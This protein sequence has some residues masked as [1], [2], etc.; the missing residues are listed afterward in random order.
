MK[1]NSTSLQGKKSTPTAKKGGDDLLDA[2]PEGIQ[3]EMNQHVRHTFALKHLVNFAK[4]SSIPD[5]V[6]IILNKDTAPLQASPI[7]F[8]VAIQPLDSQYT[9]SQLSFRTI[10]VQAAFSTL[11]HP[12]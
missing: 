2:L 7:S 1:T 12:Y 5:L 6:R 8:D 4:S 3:I 11:S 10:L 9:L